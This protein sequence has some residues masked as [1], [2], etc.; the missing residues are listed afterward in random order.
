MNFSHP[1]W[2][3]EYWNKN[4]NSI[5]TCKVLN[6]KDPHLFPIKIQSHLISTDCFHDLNPDKY[7]CTSNKANE[8]CEIKFID[9]AVLVDGYRLKRSYNK[10]KLKGWKIVGQTLLN[11]E[12]TLFEYTDN[13]PNSDPLYISPRMNN[14]SYYMKSIKIYNT[15]ENFDKT[16]FLFFLH[17]DI[18]GQYV[19]LWCFC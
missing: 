5:P 8:Y 15:L 10:N 12:K 18:F 17:F 3:I 14:S 19:K 1:E 4:Y 13:D 9:G 6:D 11:E 7:L 2:L 16:G